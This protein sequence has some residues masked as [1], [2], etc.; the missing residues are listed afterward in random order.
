MTNAKIDIVGPGEYE[1]IRGLYNSVFRPSV[2]VS[3]FARR[4]DHHKSLM[5]VAELEGQPV[6]FSCGYELRPTTY[7]SWLYGVLPDARRLGIAS[8]LMEAE[9]AWAGEHGYDMVRFECYNQHRPMLL[10]AI[11]VGYDIVGIRWDSRTAENLVIFE[12]HIPPP[13]H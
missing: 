13:G 4:L 2:D 1:L 6:G 8:Q 9:H 5:M 11:K 7:Y 12:K 10:L 3:F